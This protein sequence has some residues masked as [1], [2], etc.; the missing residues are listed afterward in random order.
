MM[1]H[2]VIPIP[3]SHGKQEIEIEMTI[4]GV[5]QQV[6][7]KVEL[8]YWADCEFSAD[9]RVDCIRQLLNEY[10]QD[11]MLYYIGAPNDDYVPVTFVNKEDWIM[12]RSWRGLN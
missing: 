2:I 6:R 9:N 8:F 1:Q 7:Y 3:P 5:R 10:N 12:Q 4:N 11:W